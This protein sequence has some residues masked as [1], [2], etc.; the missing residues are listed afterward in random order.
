MIRVDARA[1][2]A[3]MI[4]FKAVWNWPLMKFV[5]ETMHSNGGPYGA[6]PEISVTR[7]AYSAAPK[8]TPG[9]RLWMDAT[10]EAFNG[11]GSDHAHVRPRTRCVMVYVSSAIASCS[12]AA[13]V[14]GGGLFTRPVAPNYNT[15][16]NNNHD[17][18]HLRRPCRRLPRLG[19]RQSVP[20]LCA[21]VAISV[22]LRPAGADARGC[23][24]AAA[25]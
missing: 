10:H 14:R 3:T 4:Y 2:A 5:A 13:V 23:A 15:A 6:D 22:R 21:I 19:G 20:P 1:N 12:Y 9:V 11:V 24:S 25:G 18:P 7:A 8:P 16:C 17:R